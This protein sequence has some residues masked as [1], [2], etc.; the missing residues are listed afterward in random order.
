MTW[1]KICG[2]TNLEDALVAAQA[3]AGALGF[4]FAE[5]PRRIAPER[6]RDIIAKL[7]AKIEKVGV[8]VNPSLEYVRQVAQ[9]TGITRIQ[10]Q[11]DEDG[12]KVRSR[13]A[14]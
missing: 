3:G 9:Q 12:L 10:L 11:G 5:S 14:V 8:F 6:A 2:T 1:I 4:I 13:R 7:P